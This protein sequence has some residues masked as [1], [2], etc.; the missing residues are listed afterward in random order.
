MNYTYIL[1]CADDTLYTGWTND[2]KHRMD[3]H[4]HGTGSK[5][6]RTRTPVEL[7]Y[8]EEFEDKRDAQR[9][10]YQIKQLTRAHK[11]RLVQSGTEIQTMYF[12]YGDIETEY[13]KRKDKRLGEAIDRIGHIH[14]EVNAD[15]FVS[16][17][18]H[19]VGQQ[20]S[21][22]A[23]KT[24]WARLVEKLGSVSAETIGSSSR[25]D[26]QSCG[27]TFK[28]ADN[29]KDFA[30]KIHRGEFDI[31]Q[32]RDMP[33]AEVIDTLS[34]L[35]GIGVWTAEMLMTFSLQ[36]PDI[37]SFGDLGIQRGMRMLYHHKKIDRVLFSKY[38][39]RYSPYG[40]VASLYLWA[41]AGGAIPEMRDY[42]SEK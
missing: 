33:D 32:L 7:V 21:Q 18:H 27:I 4:N 9:R 17:I 39:R 2:L 29:I 14:R 10:E 1:R 16:V 28:K 42:T 11:E 34:K 3:A 36:R 20:I 6:T 23:L 5:Y 40:S 41:I 37:L 15:L 24:V 26:I 35:N 30:E 25:E 12:E 13:L 38:A 31:D 8:Y 19:M 22:A